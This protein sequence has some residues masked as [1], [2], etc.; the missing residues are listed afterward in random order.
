MYCNN[1]GEPGNE[2]KKYYDKF[3]PFLLRDYFD[4]NLRI[5]AAI[6]FVLPSIP[7]ATRNIL[8]IG[9]G[10]GW[11]T[12]EIKRC[13]N[14]ASILGIDLSS[15]T[16]NI[17]K[18][19][20]RENKKLCF[21]SQ[22]ILTIPDI[23]VHSFDAIIM[24]DSYEH[25]SK[26]SREK[27]HKF[28]NNSLRNDGVIILT[29]P[30]IFHQK[31]LKENRPNELQP[32]DEDITIKDMVKLATDVNGEIV[33]FVYKD[34]WNKNDYVHVVI[35]RNMNKC[36]KEEVSIKKQRVNIE[37]RFIRRIRSLVCFGFAIINQRRKS[38]AKIK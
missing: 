33:Y 17:A 26:E 23:Y 37:S 31:Y 14:K 28:L 25:I 27:L 1:S 22:D 3:A 29:F 38:V 9:C 11:S 5:E 20:F 10:V 12:W 18:K 34:I 36:N 7:V 8:D 19:L 2:I 24:I 35:K 6:R 15:E 30:S 21:S 16:I 32:I 13:H 4:G